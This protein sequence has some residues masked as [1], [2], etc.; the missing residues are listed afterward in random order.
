ML[1]RG[2]KGHSTGW[3][4]PNLQLHGDF[5]VQ[6]KFVD[7]DTTGP[8]DSSNGIFLRA[9]TQ[10]DMLTHAGVFRGTLR[11]PK[12]HTRQIA[13]TQF[14]RDRSGNNGV[15]FIGETAEEA[16]A[17]TLRLARRGDLIYCLLSEND[18]A[19]FRLIHVEKIATEPTIR[20]GLRL[21]NSVY[22]TMDDESSTAVT[23]QRIKMRAESMTAAR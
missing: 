5:D 1:V 23:W 7:F 13:Q 6:A 4:S 21:S 2:G 8:V 16:T 14:N 19:N 9:I 20:D 3:L 17:G 11:R 18:S 22:S 10:D 12:S 15:S